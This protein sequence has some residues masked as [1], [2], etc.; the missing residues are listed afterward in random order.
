VLYQRVGRFS[1]VVCGVTVMTFLVMIWWARMISLRGI[2]M[3]QD[4]ASRQKRALTWLKRLASSTRAEATTWE[5]SAT[6]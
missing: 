2:L 4:Y 6:D 1:I 3:L 5:L